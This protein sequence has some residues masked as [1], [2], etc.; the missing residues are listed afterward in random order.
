MKERQQ[1]IIDYQSGLYSLSELCA[2]FGISRKTGYKWL[3]RFEQAGLA[4]LSDHSRAPHSSP[5]R[6]GQDI[7]ALIRTAREQHPHW[8]PRKLQPWIA[9]HHPELAAQLPA[10]STIGDILKREGLVC[11]APR[12]RRW[13]HPNPELRAPSAANL[14]WSTD[15]KGQ[16]RLG[17]GQE[18]YPL[19]IEDG[20]SRFLLACVGLPSIERLGV[21]RVFEHVFRRYGLPE[22]IRSDNGTPFASTAICGLTKLNVW[23]IKLGIRHQ[24]IEPGHPQQNGRHERMHRTLKAETTHPPAPEQH[25]QQT[26]FDSFLSEYNTERPHEALGGRT[27]AS[28]YTPSVRPYPA[29]L[30]AP[31]YAGHMQV[32]QVS[33]A[34]CFRFNARQIFISDALIKEQIGLEETDDG[35][36]SIYF[37][38]V[39]LAR[40]D[41]RN[42]KL[43]AGAPKERLTAV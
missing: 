38:N 23:W 37:Y 9:R 25:A 13:P 34:G 41:E 1:F 42:Y 8:G 24:R 30:E 20:Y 31:E 33:N 12:R 10:I 32:R 22:A 4:G 5:Y 35:I 28:L 39:L 17:N 19:T 7:V 6:T 16:F 27:P 40:L 15:F 29:R 18:C 43:Y 36:W 3:A 14:I 2:R 21:Q 26:R 11:S